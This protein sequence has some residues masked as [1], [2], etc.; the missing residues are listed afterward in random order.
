MG[1]QYVKIKKYYLVYF[2]RKKPKYTTNTKAAVLL[3][4]FFVIIAYF[5][6]F[7]EVRIMK[8]LDHPNIGNIYVPIYIDHD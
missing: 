7:R 8:V 1:H 4:F 6:L 5:Q 2:R 3:K